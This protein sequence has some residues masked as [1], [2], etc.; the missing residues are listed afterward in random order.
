M[1]PDFRRG[2]NL[3]KIMSSGG[4]DLNKIS[5]CNNLQELEVLRIEF[6]GKQGLISLQMKELGKLDPEAR[7]AKGAELNVLKNQITEALD[8][9]RK[10]LERMEIEARLAT[11][12]L[13]LTISPRPEHQGNLHPVSVVIRQAVN[14][15]AQMGFVVAEGPEIEDDF[16]NFTALNVPENHPARQMHDTF[17]LEGAENILL[18]THTSSVQIRWMES[19]K[20]PYRIIAPGRT[21]RCDS[22]MTHTPMFHQIEGL[23]IEKNANMGHLKS[24]LKI[25]LQKFFGLLNHLQKWILVASEVAEKS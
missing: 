17:Y 20:P 23:V 6:L 5:A 14:I 7:K 21:F 24:T 25:F 10:K 22:D 11:E 1:D 3:E 15:F 12:K 4:I 19:H 9:Q 2:D 18:R 16:H 13:D 8:G